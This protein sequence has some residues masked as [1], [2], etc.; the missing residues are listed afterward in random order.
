MKTLCS[1]RCASSAWPARRWMYFAKRPLPPDH[2]L[3]SEEKIIIT[4]HIG[5]MSDIYL[6]QAYPIVRD[7]LQ[8][9]LAGDL[10]GMNNIVPH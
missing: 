6:D 1:P 2:P 8:K 4:P 9:F 7:N 10:T 5:G 3:W